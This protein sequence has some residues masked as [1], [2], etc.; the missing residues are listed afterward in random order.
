MR[1]QVGTD[2][3]NHGYGGSEDDFRPETMFERVPVRVEGQ[4]NA[5][6]EV[7]DL[8]QLQRLHARNLIHIAEMEQIALR[9]ERTPMFCSGQGCGGQR[10]GPKIVLGVESAKFIV[11]RAI[12]RRWGIDKDFLLESFIS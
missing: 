11:F 12:T 8:E 6:A 1:D 2:A 10:I 7:A 9:I 4:V 5:S 3:T